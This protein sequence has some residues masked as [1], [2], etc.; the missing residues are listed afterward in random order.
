MV[1]LEVGDGVRHVFLAGRKRLRPDR[2]SAALNSNGAARVDEVRIHDQFGPMEHVRNF[3]W[4]QVE[5]AF[6]LEFVIGEFVRSISPTRR[7]APLASMM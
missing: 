5:V 1:V 2:F 4:A 6:L 7:G 3:E